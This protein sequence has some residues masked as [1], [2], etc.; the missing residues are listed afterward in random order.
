MPRVAP[1]FD[2]HLPAWNPNHVAL[3]LSA[4]VFVFAAWAEWIHARR[5][6]A[7]GRLAFGPTGEPR[8]WTKA[9]PVLRTV[10]ATLLTWGLVILALAPSEAIDTTGS[11]TDETAPDDI[12]RIILLLDV[13]PSMAITDSGEKRN[14]ERRQRVLQVIEGIFPRISV[15]RTRFSIIAFFT[16]AR[17]VVVDAY[18]TAVIRN[19]LD[20]LPLVW[21]FEPGK[22]N[23]I[24]GLKAT[25]EMA[26]DWA[27]NSTTVILQP[28]ADLRRRRSCRRH[29]HRRPRLTTTGRFASSPCG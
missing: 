14:L 12:Q 5:S 11:D 4:V 3:L 29:V 22:T 15:A 7:L 13:S 25:A 24:E 9:T 23:V 17:P 2:L 8:S 19:V 16:S 28:G 20:N 21:A 26:R 18:D 1:W 6:A 10:A 27:P